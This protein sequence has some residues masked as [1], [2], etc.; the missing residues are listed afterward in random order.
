MFCAY[1]A[2]LGAIGWS[3]FIVCI[4][5][6]EGKSIKVELLLFSILIIIPSSATLYLIFSQ[7]LY[8]LSESDKSE[9]D[10]MEEENKILKMKIEQKK[11]KHELESN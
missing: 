10:K 7:K 2:G 9:S 1:M 8:S 5:F 11:L 6:L 4:I 3:V